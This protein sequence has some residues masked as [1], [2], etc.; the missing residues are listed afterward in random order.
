MFL[1]SR[2]EQA[3][4]H[5]SLSVRSNIGNYNSQSEMPYFYLSSAEELNRCAVVTSWQRLLD[6]IKLFCGVDVSPLLPLVNH[7]ESFYNLL[8]FHRRHSSAHIDSKEIVI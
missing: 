2:N 8:C 4:L 6:D 7:L 5:R 1:S 3:E